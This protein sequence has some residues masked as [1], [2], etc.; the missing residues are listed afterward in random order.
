[1]KWNQKSQEATGKQEAMEGGHYL[2]FWSLTQGQCWPEMGGC[3]WGK[4]FPDSVSLQFSLDFVSFVNCMLY[5]KSWFSKEG[6][7]LQSEHIL[8]CHWFI[9]DIHVGV[10]ANLLQTA[11]LSV[12][13]HKFSSDS[14]VRSFGSSYDIHVSWICSL[15]E[16]KLYWHAEKKMNHNSDTS[17]I[18]KNTEQWDIRDSMMFQNMFPSF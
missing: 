5:S 15:H 8:H 3:G 18:L 6:C 16:E 10:K 4:R 9:L 7:V 11:P 14:A 12:M 1:M 13:G 17:I 2:I